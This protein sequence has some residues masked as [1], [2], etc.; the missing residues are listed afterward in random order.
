[1]SQKTRIGIFASGRG[2]N[3]ESIIKACRQ[4]DVSAE[5]V[6]IISNNEDAYIHQRAENHGIPSFT[7][8]RVDFDE[9]KAFAS[10]L[11][12]IL[13]K[14]SVDLVLLAGYMKKI[15]PA[16]TRKWDH[17]TL[18]IHPSLLPRHGGK[19]MYGKRVHQSVIDSKD[20]FTGVSVHFVDNEY[21][22]GEILLQS[23]HVST[24]NETVESLADK[25]L[26]VEHEIYPEAVKLWISKFSNKMH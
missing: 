15:P 1:M 11:I 25:V 7:C 9:G 18:N 19:G 12:E 13:D 21:D 23:E 17:A 24:S 8:K 14:Y 5:V 3:A 6:V 20:E 16:I 4:G 10:A 26:R 22:H 2:S